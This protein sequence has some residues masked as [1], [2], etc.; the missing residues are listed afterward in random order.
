MAPAI[1]RAAVSIGLVLAALVG[2]VPVAALVV[3]VVAR[4]V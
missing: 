1:P 4:W 3:D 2:W